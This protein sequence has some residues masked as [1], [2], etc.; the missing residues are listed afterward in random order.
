MVEV[1][2]ISKNKFV[3]VKE[4]SALSGFWN[5]A[6]VKGQLG[7]SAAG[8][9]GGATMSLEQKQMRDQFSRGDVIRVAGQRLKVEVV[10]EKRFP[11]M[12]VAKKEIALG[13]FGSEL[14]YI[15]FSSAQ[16][17]TKLTDVK[18][19]Q[20]QQRGAAQAYTYQ[21]PDAKNLW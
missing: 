14:V 17:I 1:W 7:G 9:S 18:K 15:P 21:F 19:F 4:G 10:G 16:S 5:H 8:D 3:R 12:I 13:Q 2:D 6:G 11:S 20:D